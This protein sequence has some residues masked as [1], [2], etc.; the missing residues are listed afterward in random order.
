MIKMGRR[1]SPWL[2]SETDHLSEDDG[3]TL[4]EVLVAFFIL[5]ILLGL[6]YESVKSTASLSHRIREKNRTDASIELAFMKIRQEMISVYINTNDPLTYFIG[7][8][9]YSAENEHDT[10]L[11][12]TLA[13]TRLMQNAPVS[14]LEGIQYI[15]L[16]EKQR[17][18]Y[19]L[20]H[21]QDTNLFSFGTQA[22]VADPLLHHIK[23]FR[24]LYFDGHQWTNQ[25]N[26]LQSHLV[27]LMVKMEISVKRKHEAVKIFTDVFPI[28]VST[29]N[30][31]G[32][33][34]TTSGGLP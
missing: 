12:T 24:V 2:F 1:P 6:L 5:T 14:H 7:S 15:V 27:P 26:S 33:G 23:S 8:P 13:Q 25:W 17:H 22:V 11:F 28:P 32:S 19:L 29:L 31:N 16:P 30:Q 34:G 18:G 9:Q 3:F 10:L 21:E 4:L 20:A